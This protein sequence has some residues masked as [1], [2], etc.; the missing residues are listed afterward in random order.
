M[1][2]PVTCQTE[3]HA[4]CTVVVLRNGKEMS[5]DRL[6]NL[7][8]AFLYFCRHK[9]GFGV[10]LEI[11]SPAILRKVDARFHECHCHLGG[12]FAHICKVENGGRLIQG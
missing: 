9:S 4:G 1:H 3:P 6:K 12:F 5:L 11:N 10:G 8:G 2:K 7:L